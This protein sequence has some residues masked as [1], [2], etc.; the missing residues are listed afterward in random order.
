MGRAVLGTPSAFGGNGSSG[1][2]HGHQLPEFFGDFAAAE[3]SFPEKSAD[4]CFEGI[5]S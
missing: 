1:G 2:L 3:D 4:N 5:G